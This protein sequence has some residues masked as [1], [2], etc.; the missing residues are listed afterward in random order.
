MF[1]GLALFI[2]L[3]AAA[4][5]ALAQAPAGEP[6]K[7]VAGAWELSNADRDRVCPVTLKNT[8][9]P[10]LPIDWDRK[11]AELFPFTREVRSW[12]IGERDVLAL[13]DAKG[14]PVLE[15]MEVEGGLYEGERPGEGLVFLQSVAGVASEQRNPEEFFAQW[16]LV[17]AGKPVC[18]L[19]F[20]NTAAAQDA[21]A[22]QVKP[23][24]DATVTRFNPVAWRLDRGQLVLIPTRGDGWRFEEAEPGSWKR[25]PDSRQSLQLVK[26]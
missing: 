20:T 1:R 11:C 16:K 24:C 25:I 12:K 6:A 19:T 14:Q 22:V 3:F 21:Y 10:L 9:G 26:Q 13:L 18:E 17:R 4:L 23:G 5:P 8:G 7:T 2:L 15:L